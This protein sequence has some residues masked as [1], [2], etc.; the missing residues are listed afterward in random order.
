MEEE[1]Q[2]TKNN[3]IFKL[4]EGSEELQAEISMSSFSKMLE[5]YEAGYTKNGKAGSNW[6]RFH[7]KEP[8]ERTKGLFKDQVD[9]T[10]VYG[11]K[12]G[13][14]AECN[15]DSEPVMIRLL[16]GAKRYMEIFDG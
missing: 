7:E 8:P 10:F 14:R 4:F 3:P 13:W 16:T 6:E 15:Y 2:E 1:A 9:I 12:L 11:D 5:L